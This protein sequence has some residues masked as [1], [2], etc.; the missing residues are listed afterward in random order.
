MPSVIYEEKGIFG[1]RSYEGS[2]L[3]LKRSLAIRTGNLV[4]MNAN[5]D[6]IGE[7]GA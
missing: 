6:H 1:M 7:S 5:I 3:S 4:L 2:D